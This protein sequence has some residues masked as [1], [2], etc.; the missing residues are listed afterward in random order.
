MEVEDFG[1]PR[2]LTTAVLVEARMVSVD[3]CGVAVAD[4]ET[5][6]GEIDLDIELRKAALFARMEAWS[7]ELLGET[8]ICEVDGIPVSS[9][10][11][12]TRLEDLESIE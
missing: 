4:L 6:G 12:L 1:G 8:P 2:V 9:W 10:A 11:N 7:L 3:G 5:P